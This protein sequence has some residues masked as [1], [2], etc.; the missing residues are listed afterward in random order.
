M[1]SQISRTRSWTSPWPFGGAGRNVDGC[2]RNSTASTKYGATVGSLGSDPARRQSSISTI[3]SG[4]GTTGAGGNSSGPDS[5]T[6][7]D[8]VSTSSGR[9]P[10]VA[11]TRQLLTAAPSRIGS[12]E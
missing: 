2:W 5:P 4:G 10:W 9:E 8:A 1:R 7:N 6:W 12:T 11:L 3:S